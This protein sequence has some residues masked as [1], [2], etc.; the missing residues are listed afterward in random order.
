MIIKPFSEWREERIAEAGR[1]A[2]GLLESGVELESQEIECVDCKGEGAVSCDCNCPR[3]EGWEDCSA[4]DGRGHIETTDPLVME[5]VEKDKANHKEYL[6]QLA[7]DLVALSEWLG[8][9]GLFHIID[10]GL[11]PATIIRHGGTKT[12]VLH[13]PQRPDIAVDAPDEAPRT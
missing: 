3:C 9:P 10:A 6:Q 7:R 12:L 8:K 11:A 2:C 1:K 5:E 13:D 4:C